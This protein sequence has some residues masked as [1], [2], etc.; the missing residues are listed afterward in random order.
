MTERRIR[1]GGVARPLP[2]DALVRATAQKG[3]RHEC[4]VAPSSANVQ[5]SSNPSCATHTWVG[6]S[7]MSCQ[8]APDSEQTP[9]LMATEIPGCFLIDPKIHRDQ[10]GQLV[11]LS[12]A[13]T[14]VGIGFGVDGGEVFWSN[15]AHGVLRGLHFQRAPREVGKI[16]WCTNGSVHDVVLDLRPHSRAF[17]RSIGYELSSINGRGMVVPMGC[18]HGFLTM[19]EEATMCYLQSG[20]FDPDCDSGIRWDTA[21]IEWPDTGRPV[22]TSPRDAAH[23]SFDEFIHDRRN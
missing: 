17:G 15:S 12:T 1:R 7:P 9:S 11:K 3:A 5:L 16:V 19:S 23:P 21:G 6:F 10:R 13:S 14:F 20:P 8:S 22:T 2:V 18:A 4:S